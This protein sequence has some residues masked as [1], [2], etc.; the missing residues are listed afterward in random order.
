MANVVF[1]WHMHQ[2]YYVNPVSRVAMMPWVRLH[3]VKGYLDMVSVLGEFPDV[4]VNFNLTPVLML[5]IEELVQGKIRDLWLDWSRKPAADLDENERL[6]ILE[7]FF[8]IQHDNLLK[9]F[10]RYAELLGKRG[11]NFQ[12]DRVRAELRHWS[13]EDFRDLQTWYNLAWCGF[14]ASRLYPELGA[15][16]RKGRGFSEQE[17]LRVLDIHMEILAGIPQLYADAEARG[18]AELTTTPFFHPILPLVYDSDFAARS[19]PGRALPRRFHWPQDAEA[20]LR[21][22]VEQH[23]R[24]FGRAPRGLWPSE[25]SIAPELV[26]LMEKV[27][28]QYFCSDEENL[29]NSLRR[30]GIHA[31]HLELFQGWRVE[32]ECAA[33]NA[34]FREKPLSDFV[35]FMASRS[36][37][38][39]SAEHLLSHM[40]HIADHIPRDGGLIPIILDGENAWE[41][42]RDG[43]ETFLREL[44]RG[45]EKGEERLRSS[46]I[47]NY[48][49]RCPP[50]KTLHKLH[51]GSWIYSN[52]DIWIG[53]DEENR[54]WDLLGDTRRFLEGMLPSLTPQQREAALHEVYA[55][56]GSDWFWWYGPDFSTECDT[57][58]DELFRQ[59]LKNVY[60]ICGESFPPELN[61][62]V[63]STEKPALYLPPRRQIS[64]LING[65]FAPFY[66]WVGAGFYV[67]GS[68]QGAMFRDDRYL[69]TVRFGCDTQRLYLRFD[70]R[71][72]GDFTVGVIF[73]QP[74]GLI[75]RTPVAKRGSGGK[76][77]VHGTDGTETTAGEFAVEKIIELSVPFSV[78]KVTPGMVLQFQVKVFERG[79]E[80]ECYP[81]SSP[82]ALTVPAADSALAEWVV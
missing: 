42:F 40:R 68:E 20:H 71:R 18:Q 6:A 7:H 9:P 12:R 26:P 66:E 10:P 11:A 35:G 8:K 29:F 41:T 24:M 50:K 59:H 62:T 58:F 79:K 75:V 21:L 76:V 81:E 77:T 32:H 51:S 72:T 43:G 27:G 52:F 63:L 31:D 56:E 61:R 44:Y 5:Q 17:K 15:L 73:H 54:A 69:R 65:E 23:T 36:D 60:S 13:T 78:L 55:A 74:A 16:K 47:E 1:L 57:L 33:V 53:E 25:G 14:T 70:L 37:P 80:C 34:V 2:P 3:A 49:H 67:A 19:M 45:L 46:T 22:A 38:R 48:L 4:H 39:D 30:E 64:P 82:I 28:I